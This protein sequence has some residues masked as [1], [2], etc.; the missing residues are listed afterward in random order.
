MESALNFAQTL[1]DSTFADLERLQALEN[2]SKEALDK[3]VS[4]QT[5]NPL[6]TERL[7]FYNRS[8]YDVSI[9]RHFVPYQQ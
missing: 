9:P 5:Q 3:A 4:I 7:I 8:A 1:A 6:V 2:T